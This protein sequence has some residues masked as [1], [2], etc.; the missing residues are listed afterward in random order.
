MG[1]GGSAGDGHNDENAESMAWLL[2]VGDAAVLG[3]ALLA[4]TV[5]LVL[6]YALASDVS[7]LAGHA[8]KTALAE[9]A[10]RQE[11][12]AIKAGLG[13]TGA[14]V[15]AAPAAPERTVTEPATAYRAVARP[16][17]VGADAPVPVCMFYTGGQNQLASCIRRALRS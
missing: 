12:A 11:L 8:R 17:K 6:T 10:L 16:M 5:S 7:A 3:L 1:E 13:A 15:G 9:Q 2:P 14:A 4:M